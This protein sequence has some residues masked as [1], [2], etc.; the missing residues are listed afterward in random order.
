MHYGQILS[1]MFFSP[2]FMVI[3]LIGYISLSVLCFFI[4]VYFLKFHVWNHNVWARIIL[5]KAKMLIAIMQWIE[6]IFYN[7]LDLIL[8]KR[9]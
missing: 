3:F 8:G 9:V 6:T 2:T 5:F 1:S 7:I 4:F